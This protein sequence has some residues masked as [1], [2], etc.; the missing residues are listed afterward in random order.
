MCD[1]GVAAGRG[2]HGAAGADAQD[3]LRK[4]RDELARFNCSQH[5]VIKTA[6]DSPI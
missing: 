5:G 4:R 6:S 2:A 3:Q 1:A